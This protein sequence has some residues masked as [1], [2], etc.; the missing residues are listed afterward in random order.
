LNNAIKHSRAKT[1]TIQLRR[2]K[3]A[4]L[5]EVSDDGT[6]M[7]KSRATPRGGLGLGVMQHRASVIGAELAI[8]S[9]RG[10]GVTIRCTLPSPS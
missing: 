4:L 8:G 3:G 6:G 5:L 1:V 7:A 9:K 2:E 10:E